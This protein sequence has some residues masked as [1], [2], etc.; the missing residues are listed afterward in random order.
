MYC[1]FNEFLDS[2]IES[3]HVFDSGSIGSS[4]SLCPVWDTIF[5]SFVRISQKNAIERNSLDKAYNV[6]YNTI[7][8]ISIRKSYLSFQVYF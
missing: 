1:G 3:F 7:H 5:S 4:G 6:V 2:R 8:K